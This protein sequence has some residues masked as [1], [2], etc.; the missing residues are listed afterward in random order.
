MV[1]RVEILEA[2]VLEG[3]PQVQGV[4]EAIGFK[5]ETVLRNQAKDQNGRRRNVLLLT[6]DVSELWDQMEDL[7]MELEYI[8]RGY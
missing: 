8:P 2:R 6:N 5:L 4:F 7:I 1:Q 3:Q